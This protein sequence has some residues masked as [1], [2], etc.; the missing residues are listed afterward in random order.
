MLGETGDAVLYKFG[1]IDL[2][3]DVLMEKVILAAETLYRQGETDRVAK[4]LLSTLLSKDVPGFCS[5]LKEACSI[6]RCISQ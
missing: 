5:E 1:I 4:K 6:I 2:S 3:L